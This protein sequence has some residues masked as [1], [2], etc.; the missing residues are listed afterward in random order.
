MTANDRSSLPPGPGTVRLSNDGDAGA[1]DAVYKPVGWTDP[2]RSAGEIFDGPALE[3]QLIR[4]LGDRYAGM[5]VNGSLFDVGVIAPTSSDEVLVAPFGRIVAATYSMAD[6]MR[7]KEAVAAA[8]RSRGDNVV[9]VDLRRNKIVLLGDQAEDARAELAQIAPMDALDLRDTPARIT[10]THSSRYN[11]NSYFVHQEAG[12]GVITNDG[13]RFC[14]TGFYLWN[15]SY[16]P[17]GSTAGHCLTGQVRAPDNSWA[18]PVNASQWGPDIN[19]EIFSTAS[20]GNYPRVHNQSNGHWGVMGAFS[21]TWPRQ[22]EPGVCW[23]GAY[24]SNGD[25]CGQVSWWN[26]TITGGGR[27]VAHQYCITVGPVEGDSGGPMYRLYDNG[28]VHAMGLT[29]TRV[30]MVGNCG[31]HIQWVLA[32][33]GMQLPIQ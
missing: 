27:N 32:V 13:H 11:W 4:V 30:E 1:N 22:G 20:I 18:G 29:S 5:W 14:T 2:G 9:S 25:F 33:L 17:F 26:V 6:L 12:L 7:W 23:S 3:Q 10:P 28:T 16:G 15:A 21:D 19:A 31:T 8:M 24:G